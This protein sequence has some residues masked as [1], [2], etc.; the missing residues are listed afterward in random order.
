MGDYGGMSASLVRLQ[1]QRLHVIESGQLNQI[2]VNKF[3]WARAIADATKMRIGRTSDEVV[4]DFR[5]YSDA[6]DL[7]REGILIIGLTTAVMSDV[8]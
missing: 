1:M 8:R 7:E 2:E 6:K 4:E 3:G 5:Q